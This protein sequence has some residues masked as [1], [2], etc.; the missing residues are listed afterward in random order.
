MVGIL[1]RFGKNY[2]GIMGDIGKMFLQIRFKE[3]D[4]DSL[5]SVERFKRQGNA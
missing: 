4:R 3:E 1:L 2:V 5:V